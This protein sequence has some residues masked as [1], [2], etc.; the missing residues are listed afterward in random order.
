MTSLLVM[1]P[2]RGRK[3]Q[4]E[5]L[6]VSFVK[7][8]VRETTHLLFITDSDD[9]ESY[10]GMDWGESSMGIIEPREYLTGKLNRTADSMVSSYD[11]L[12]FAGDDHVFETKGW[13]DIMLKTLEAAGGT[14]M[15]YPDDKRRTD[16]PEI[17]MIS[18]DIVAILGQFA[19][20]AM[21][22]YYIDNAWAELGKRTG[23]IHF[24]PD[25]VVTHKHYSVDKETVKDATY[26]EAEE[27]WGQADM[28][29]YQ[30][31]LANRMP[32]QVSQLRRAF[33]DDVDWVLG[34]I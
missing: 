6:L 16:V 34:R 14:G 24:C 17:I 3:T 21:K 12:M 33:N 1:V 22:H 10:E 11:A 7:N 15:V 23:L 20:A 26:S 13:D 28:A 5:R 4:C 29:A 9:Q 25:A 30:W 2:T 18:S 32:V 8:T 19:E 31:W 27:L